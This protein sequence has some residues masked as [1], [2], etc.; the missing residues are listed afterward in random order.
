MLVTITASNIA[1]VCARSPLTKSMQ[2]MERLAQGFQIED[3][4]LDYWAVG[5][6]RSSTNGGIHARNLTKFI[7]KL[8]I[9]GIAV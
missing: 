9:Y 7:Y 8:A 5:V 6:R 1:N 2:A 4:S 3:K